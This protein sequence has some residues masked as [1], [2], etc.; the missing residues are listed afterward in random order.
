[1]NWCVNYMTAGHHTFL[2]QMYCR[3]MDQIHAE[4]IA[5]ALAYA[6]SLFGMYYLVTVI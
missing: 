6:E 2:W 4:L 1:M 3:Q 5:Y